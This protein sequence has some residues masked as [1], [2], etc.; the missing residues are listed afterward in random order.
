MGLFCAVNLFAGKRD[1]PGTS[2]SRER[3]I[4]IFSRMPLETVSSVDP[5]LGSATIRWGLSV[6]SRDSTVFPSSPAP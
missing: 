3:K 4:N 1:V 5:L 2:H 6:R